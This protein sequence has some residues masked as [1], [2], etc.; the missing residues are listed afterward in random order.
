MWSDKGS[1]FQ[2][3][4]IGRILPNARISG[5]QYVTHNRSLEHHLQF[6]MVN[7]GHGGSEGAQFVNDRLFNKILEENFVEN[8]QQSI[9]NGFTKTDIELQ[10]QH[11]DGL[12]GTCTTLA[13]IHGNFLY[14]ANVGNCQAVLSSNDKSVLLTELHVPNNPSE[15][16]RVEKEGGK[17]LSDSVGNLRLGHPTWNSKLINIG[18]TRSFG[19]FYFKSHEWIQNNES[20]LTSLPN[21][22]Q[23]K[24]TPNDKF[25]LMATDGLW[26]FVSPKEAVEFVKKYFQG[27][28]ERICQEL[29]V[30]SRHRGSKDNMTVMLV[31]FQ[32]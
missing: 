24:L 4:D 16:T 28:C 10:Q 22:S 7:D 11:M 18:V 14:V 20:G 30:W 26:D 17:L 32:E 29:I 25:L 12:I 3:E 5:S 1:Y 8:P 2:M 23:R 9:I 6:F 13:I 19:D 31:K 15:K 21:V 27:N